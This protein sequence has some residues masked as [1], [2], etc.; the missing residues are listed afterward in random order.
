MKEIKQQRKKQSAFCLDLMERINKD[1]EKYENATNASYPDKHT[2]I[3][4]DIKRLRRELLE[5]SKMYEWEY[6]WNYKE[7]F[8]ER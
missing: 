8:E 2:V 6:E 3:Q 1:I 5:L 4:T 7:K